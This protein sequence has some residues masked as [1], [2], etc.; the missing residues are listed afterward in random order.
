MYMKMLNCVRDDSPKP[1]AMEVDLGPE[2][3]MSALGH[4]RTYASQ[5]AM[6]ALAPIATVLSDATVVRVGVAPA[7]NILII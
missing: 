2:S 1:A 7:A 6:S 4:K 5:Q 3:K